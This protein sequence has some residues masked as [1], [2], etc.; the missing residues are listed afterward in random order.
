MAPVE[1]RI[2][3]AQA[4]DGVSTAF[5]KSIVVQAYLTYVSDTLILSVAIARRWGSAFS[6]VLSSTALIVH[7]AQT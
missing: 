2:D 6:E 7:T 4:R 5:A 1:P 3:Y